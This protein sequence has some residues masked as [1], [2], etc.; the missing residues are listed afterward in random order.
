MT[1][2]RREIV[3]LD[4]P[5]PLR[6]VWEHLRDPALV[7]RWYGWDHP[8]LDAEIRRLFVETMVE[9][10]D[11]EGDTTVHRVRWEH[12]HVKVWAAAHEPR[13]TRLVMT[14]PSHQ[15]TST[16]DGVRDEVDEAWT[17]W[18][19]QLQFALTRHLDVERRTLS[20]FGLDAG[21]ARDRL[22]DRAGLVGIHGVVV[23]GNVQARRPD[24]TL[25]GGTLDYRTAQQI[26]LR[27]HGITESYLVL[28]E[29]PA[30]SHPPHGQVHAIMSTYG[31]DDA[32]F[33]EVE[34]R[35]AS[36]WRMAGGRAVRAG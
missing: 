32:T 35:W 18:L 23:G 10:R 8:G 2:E 22:L 30:A 34:R 9:T 7:R 27:L 24:G 11:V 28:Q 1:L 12:N 31:L 19:H 36:W 29:V 13:H 4:I 26:G 17:A 14:R 25:L 20:S 21:D 5:V 16:F 6:T 15:G 33:E 3:S